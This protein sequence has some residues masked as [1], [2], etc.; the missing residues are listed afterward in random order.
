M[1]SDEDL[2]NSLRSAATSMSRA[3]VHKFHENKVK[4]SKRFL[5]LL[6]SLFTNILI[7]KKKTKNCCGL[8]KP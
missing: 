6:L 2:K 8:D 3:V 5:F 1:I 4:Y 7:K